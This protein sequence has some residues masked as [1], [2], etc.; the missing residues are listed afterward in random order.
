VPCGS[1]PSCYPEPMVRAAVCL[2][3][4]ATA[5]VVSVDASHVRF[6]CDDEPVCPEGFTCTDGKC[7]PEGAAV[8][9]ASPANDRGPDAA[10]SDA[11]AA[12]DAPESDA[13]P[14]ASCDELYG[15]APDYILCEQADDSCAFN[16][17]LD[18]DSCERLCASFGGVC[19]AAFD[20]PNTSGDECVIQGEDTCLRQR[21]T[22]I[23]VCSR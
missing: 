13:A 22:E 23:C 17:R 16:V 21:G 9:D 1:C 18:N 11:A 12:A 6:R 3:L 7:E 4:A 2:V 5:C 10:I 20:N 8:V 19:V 15:A 14:P